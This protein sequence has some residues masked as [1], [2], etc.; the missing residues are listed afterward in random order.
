MTDLE[1]FTI[2]VAAESREGMEAYIRQTLERAGVEG[3]NISEGDGFYEGGLFLVLTGSVVSLGVLAAS[4]MED[5]ETD[6]LV[7][8][9]WEG[10]VMGVDIKNRD[11]SRN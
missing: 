5:F 11:A 9:A 7:R 4:M 8:V 6:F 1:R 10:H 3:V 2:K